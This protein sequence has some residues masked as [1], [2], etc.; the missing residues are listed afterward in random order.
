MARKNL[1]PSSV[2]GPEAAARQRAVLIYIRVSTDAQASNLLSLEDQETQLLAQCKR[3]NER[4]AGIYREEGETATNMRRRAFEDM[5]ER[6]DFTPR[7]M[8]DG[9]IGNHVSNRIQHRPPFSRPILTPPIGSEW[10][11]PCSA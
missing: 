11:Y 9:L 6:H 2:G 10:A 5:I 4:V 3:E 7:R 1:T 8:P